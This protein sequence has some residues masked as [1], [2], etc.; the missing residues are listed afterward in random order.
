MQSRRAIGTNAATNDS[1]ELAGSAYETPIAFTQA[2]YLQGLLKADD[3]GAAW[4]RPSV[5]MVSRVVQNTSSSI[6]SWN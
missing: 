3:A 4:N 5:T 6:D 2:T 1:A